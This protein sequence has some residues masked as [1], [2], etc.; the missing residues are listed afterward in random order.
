MTTRK[1]EG[2]GFATSGALPTIV[3]YSA[4]RERLLER[5]RIQP[6]DLVI[7]DLR[8]P[9]MGGIQLLEAIKSIDSQVPVIVITAYGSLDS[10]I[11]ALRLGA[12]DFIKKPY[13]MEEL[14]KQVARI[15]GRSREFVESA[16]SDRSSNTGLH[17]GMVGDSD[18]MNKV[19][20][21]IQKL[22]GAHCSIFIHG[23][24]G[25]GKELAARAIHNAGPRFGTPFVVVDCG[26]ITDSLLESE[27]FGHRRGAFTGAD[28]DRE[29]LLRTAGEGTGRA[30]CPKQG[31]S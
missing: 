12:T 11:D 28:R 6:A 21:A 1:P 16:S 2:F 25:T 24:S 13:D 14:E 29:G 8:M 4:I 27:L 7:T 9:H 5:F 3:G 20:R 26:G 17:Y 15:L 22:A 23:E 31:A 30:M 18:A 19:Y 10:A